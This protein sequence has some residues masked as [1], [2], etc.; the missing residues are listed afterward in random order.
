MC[1]SQRQYDAQVQKRILKISTD[2][3]KGLMV[4]ITRDGYP[5]IVAMQNSSVPDRLWLKQDP[6]RITNTSS[7]E[8]SVKI[9]GRLSLTIA[10]CSDV[11]FGRD[12]GHLW[13]Q[14]MQ[15]ERHYIAL[16]KPQ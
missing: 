8:R 14:G 11:K 10:T 4:V 13:S 6:T 16:G 1:R 5:E 7:L 2:S 9:L 15:A 12:N 3:F